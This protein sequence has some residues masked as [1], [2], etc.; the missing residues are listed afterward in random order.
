MALDPP[1]QAQ[2]YPAKLRALTRDHLGFELEE[3]SGMPDGALGWSARASA[4]VYLAETVV[5]RALGRTLVSAQDRGAEQIHVICADEAAMVARRA[6][7]FKMPVDVWSIGTDGLAAAEP[8][9]HAPSPVLPEATVAL[10][11]DIVA[12]GADP[13]IEHGVLVGE[14]RGLEIVRA[15]DRNGVVELGVGV[16]DFDREVFGLIHG[17]VPTMEAV[18]EVVE[19]VARHRC[20]GADPHPLNRIVSERWLRSLLIDEPGRIGFSTLASAEPPVARVSVKETM[21]AIAVGEL[22]GEEWVVAVSTGIDLDLVPY[23]ADAR[24]KLAPDA[25]LAIVVP[26]R[27]AHRVTSRL[28]AS[29]EIPA[30][31]IAIDDN[32]RSWS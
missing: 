28:A 10:T 31:L 12:A 26:S 7:T 8:A 24:L 15:E 29:L 32:W 22:G 17:D 25:P 27:D 19:T 23:A 4:V 18:R 3:V 16:G 14:V 2:F 30:R 1:Q 21:P 11:A 20:P 9:P 5:G 6:A 13:V